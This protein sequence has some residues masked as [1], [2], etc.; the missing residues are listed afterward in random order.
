MTAY[1]GGSLTAMYGKGFVRAPKGSTAIDAQGNIVDVSGL[2][3]LDNQNMP[4]VSPDLQ[5][6]GDCAPKCKGGFNTSV[7]WKGLTAS[8]SFDGQ[9]GGHVFSYTNWVLNYRGKG[10][11]TLEGREGGLVAPGVRQ[12]PDGNYVINTIAFSKENID[13]WYMN[14]YDMTN[15]EVNFVSTQ[16]L[17]LREVRLEYAFPKKLLAKTKFLSQASIALYANNLWCWSDFPGWDP[18]AVTMRGSAVVPGFEI[19]QMPT[20]AQF[21][22]SINLTF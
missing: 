4:Q 16:F 12:T 10:V 8:I 15:A 7:K 22:G 14:Y 6:L 1:E 20:T 2:L 13:E 19:L 18:E 17:K 21:G 11:K 3:V 5:Y 9:I